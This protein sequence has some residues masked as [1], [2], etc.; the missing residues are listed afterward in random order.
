MS[1]FHGRSVWATVAAHAKPCGARN[2]RS[3]AV[4]FVPGPGGAVEPIRFP[5]GST[6]RERG[7][8]EHSFSVVRSVW[9]WK[10]STPGRQTCT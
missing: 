10:G 6:H 8:R 2:G 4:L 5:G 7:C 1:E 3:P 9:D